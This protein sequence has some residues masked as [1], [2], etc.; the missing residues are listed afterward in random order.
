WTNQPHYH[1]AYH[2]NPREAASFLKENF[3]PLKDQGVLEYID[4]E[5]G[6]AFNSFIHFDFAYGHTEAMMIPFISL[7]NGKKLVYCADLLPSHYHVPMPYVMSYDVRPLETM[8]EKE[9]F[10]EKVSDGNHILFFE[11]DPGLVCGS[12]IKN[13][14]GKYVFHEALS[15]DKIL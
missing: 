11:H 13:E 6:I 15:F 9:S 1:W 8:K 5:Q 10:F 7:P 3:V 14:A 2:T 4:T 12:V